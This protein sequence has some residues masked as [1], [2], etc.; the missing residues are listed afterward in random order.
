MQGLACFLASKPGAAETVHSD[1]CCRHATLAA[2][3]LGLVLANG[4]QEGQRTC[5]LCLREAWKV[6]LRSLSCM[7]SRA[8]L[9]PET[10]PISTEPAYARSF[11]ASSASR[12]H[13]AS[14][15]ETR[16]PARDRPQ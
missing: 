2:V 12:L 6:R 5:R 8:H 11:S 10:A 9:Q 15:C 1:L 3:S 4:S 14:S 7:E 13:A 16:A